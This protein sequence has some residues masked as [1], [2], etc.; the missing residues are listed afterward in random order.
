MHKIVKRAIKLTGNILTIT[1]VALIIKNLIQLEI[2]FTEL[3]QRGSLLWV[4]LLTTLNTVILL[5]SCLPWYLI[6]NSVFENKIKFRD[7][8]NI[9]NKSNLLKYVPGNL[10]QYIGRNQIAFEYKLSNKITALTT[11]LDIAANTIGILVLVILLCFNWVIEWFNKFGSNRPIALFIAI[12]FFIIG[13]IIY[14]KNKKKKINK[15]FNIKIFVYSIG[16]YIFLGLIL[17]WIYYLIL[18]QILNVHI[19]VNQIK[20]LVGGFQLSWLIGFITPG[21]PG[22]IGIREASI[23]FFLG[24]TFTADAVLQGIVIMRLINIIADLSAYAYSNIL[25]RLCFKS[26]K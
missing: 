18:E 11:I 14:Q 9:W 2:N 24:K 5:C 26:H 25:N 17:G 8:Q 7:V 21:S 20:N 1:A 3:L 13:S 12:I 10:F 22:G 15:L 23:L 16:I 19:E 4:V 6:L